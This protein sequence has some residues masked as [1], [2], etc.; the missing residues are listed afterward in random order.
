MKDATF[1]ES[2]YGLKRVSYDKESK[3]YK[4]LQ[5]WQKFLTAASIVSLFEITNYMIFF[6][7]MHKCC[8][9]C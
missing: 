2:L 3:S 4:P 5:D 8:L 6:V 7:C 1:M 9:N